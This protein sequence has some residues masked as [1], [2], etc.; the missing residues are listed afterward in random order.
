MDVR[1]LTLLIPPLLCA[2]REG[3]TGYGSGGY[4]PF[5]LSLRTSSEKEKQEE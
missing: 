5:P 1:E 3:E 2:I 4:H